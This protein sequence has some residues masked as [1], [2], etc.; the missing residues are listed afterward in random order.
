[1]ENEFKNLWFKTVFISMFYRAIELNLSFI[2]HFALQNKIKK[3]F[4]SS[5]CL[6]SYWQLHFKHPQMQIFNISP[7][8]WS[9]EYFLCF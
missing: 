2:Q 9:K 6:L 5:L 4:F 7:S 1:M 8:E 3:V